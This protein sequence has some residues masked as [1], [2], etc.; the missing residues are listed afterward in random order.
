[1]DYDKLLA[2]YMTSEEWKIRKAMFMD[3]FGH[4]FDPYKGT[5]RSGTVYLLTDVYLEYERRDA[6]DGG[7]PFIT[8]PP[9]IF[10]RCFSKRCS[11]A[12][13]FAV[14]FGSWWGLLPEKIARLTDLRLEESCW[15]WLNYFLCDR[16]AS[17]DASIDDVLSYRYAGK[18]YAEIH[19]Q[20]PRAALPP[21]P[22][23]VPVKEILPD[24]C[25]CYDDP[26]ERENL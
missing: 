4:C 5:V 8:V 13:R 12:Q 16:T 14:I 25:I 20:K 6:A 18:Y 23:R 22:M 1:M 24:G 15:D 3:S 17:P 7:Y 10:R 26:E 9:E 21:D 11:D 19:K 2:Y